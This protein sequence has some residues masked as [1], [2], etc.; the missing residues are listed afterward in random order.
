METIFYKLIYDKQLKRSLNILE[1]LYKAKHAVTMKELQEK[2][3]I[4]LKSVLPSLEFTKTLLPDNIELTVSEKI[5]SLHQ[6]DTSQ[7]IDSALIEIAKSTIPYQILK[8]IFYD[9]DIL[10]AELAE[11]LFVSESSLRIYIKH[12]NRTMTFF[13]LSISFRDVKLL[14]DETNIRYF[15]YAYFSEF[16]ELFVSVCADE[17]E[18][19]SGLYKNMRKMQ[20]EYDDKLIHY[21]YQQI[22]RWLFIVRD[23]LEL[24]K[25]VSVKKS[26]AKRI[27]SHPSFKNFKDIYESEIT[28][29]LTSPNIPISEVI[30][31]YVVSFNSII[32]TND[33]NHLL[34]HDKLD[35]K[36]CQNKLAA[37]LKNVINTLGVNDEDYEDFFAIHMAYL[38]NLSLLTEISPIFQ[39][40]SDS[41]KNYVVGNLEYLYTTWLGALSRL[42]HDKIFTITNSYSIAS[43]LAMISSQFIYRQKTQVKKILFSFEGESGFAVYLETLAKAL[44]PEGVEA[45]FVY[46]VPINS[47]TIEKT[48]PDIFVCNYQVNE[49][50]DNCK[51]LRLSYVPLTQE[52]KLLKELIINPN[53]HSFL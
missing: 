12:M 45:L 26:L 49:K 23:R 22:S 1:I 10:I 4:S 35:S 28:K 38:L 13:G 8:H 30:W 39:L 47:K 42:Q 16:Q 41:I 52:W 37:V 43:Q 24:G 31:A 5:V 14:G 11:M 33:K 25:F 48:K 20:L 32:Y 3:N 44:V 46:N 50:F 19:F 51:M 18:Y 6:H 15:F 21:S 36:S 29:T 17:L 7:P 27:Q 34:Y 40:G 2:L 53:W 9:G